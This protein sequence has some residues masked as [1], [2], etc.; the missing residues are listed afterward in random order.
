MKRLFRMPAADPQ[1]RP[2]CQQ[3]LRQM[4]AEKAAAADQRDQPAFKIARPALA[5]IRQPARK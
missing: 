4:R 5:H 1:A 2:A 3:F